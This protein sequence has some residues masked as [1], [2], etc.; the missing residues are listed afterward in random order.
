MRDALLAVLTLI[1]CVSADAL[2]CDGTI[3]QDTN[4][5]TGNKEKVCTVWDGHDHEVYWYEEVD[6]S[7]SAGTQ[8]TDN[9]ADDVAPHFAFDDNGA[10]AVVWRESGT[11]GRI[12]YRARKDDNGVWTWQSSAVAVSDGTEDASAAWVVFHDGDT[13]WV[14]WHEV[15]SSGDTKLMGGGTNNGNPWPTAFTTYE[16]GTTSHSGN[17]ML[18]T[19]SKDGHLW[20]V[21][22][23][24]SSQ[25]GYSE[26]DDIDEEWGVEEHEAYDGESDVSDAKQRVE[27]TIAP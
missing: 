3:Y 12:Y 2:A 21:W 27:D 23:D 16:V 13:P 5:V 26:W 1:V 20:M 17:F 18:E 6:G 14:G 8:L 4:P 25:L 7:W 24:S 22:V 11:N 9:A 19:Q 15:P 10:T